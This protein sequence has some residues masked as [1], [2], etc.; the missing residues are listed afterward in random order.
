MKC[1]G[2]DTR[3]WKPGDI[4]EVDCPHC[5]NK[6][7]FFKDEATRRCRGC[8]EMVVNPRMNFGCASYCQ[9][10]S[11]CLGELGP[12]LLAKRNDLLKDRVAIEVKRRLGK[13]FQ[14][15]AHAINVARYAEEI[16][17]EEKAEPALVLCAAYLHLLME[18]Q[19]ESSPSSGRETAREIMDRLG[20]VP[21][22]RDKVLEII[23]HSLSEEP[24]D[25]LDT[26]VFLDAHLLAAFVEK[27]PGLQ[28]GQREEEDASGKYLTDSGRILG[29]KLRVT[30]S[31]SAA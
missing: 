10:A 14:K 9:Y 21:E 28:E 27:R 30:Y 24:G 8:K 1:P 3:Y 18:S 17:R 16:A 31:Q 25:S 7:E 29:E 13:N 5:K 12:E 19:E 26:K 23:G 15:I 6:V 22:L 4:F 11:Q 20:A 2:Q